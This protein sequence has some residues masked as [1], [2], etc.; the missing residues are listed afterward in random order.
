MKGSGDSGFKF[1]ASHLEALIDRQGDTQ[2]SFGSKPTCWAKQVCKA[3]DIPKNLPCEKLGRKDLL[4]IWRNNK[5][6]RYL[7]IC[8]MS[9]GGMRIYNGKAAWKESSSWIPLIEKLMQP[10][11]DRTEIYEDFHTANLK[12]IGPAF[13]TKLIFFA[14]HSRPEKTGFIMDQ[15]TAKSIN[16]LL[17][18]NLVT[19][20]KAGYVAGSGN[21]EKN[22]AGVYTE[23]CLAIE[24][25][26]NHLECEPAIA[27]ETLFSRGRSR[28]RNG[29]PEGQWRTY[30]RQHYKRQ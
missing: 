29:P 17:G 15:W 21:C 18:R 8:T 30:V 7:F 16:L 6:P 5:D 23:F 27:E 13:F 25:L 2:E 20:S 28:F 4:D 3:R 26:A 14:T 12:G 11:I 24:D 10:D 19:L 1:D 9:W 22:P